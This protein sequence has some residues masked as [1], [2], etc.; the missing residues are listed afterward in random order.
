VR[1]LI[2]TLFFVL[3][4][5]PLAIAQPVFDAASSIA[6]DAVIQL[7]VAHTATGANR[8]AVIGVSHRV[9]TGQSITGISYGAQTPTSVIA[10]TSSSFIEGVL[11]RLI[12]PNTGSQ[13]LTV[14][15]GDI[16]DSAV[17]GVSTFT[18]VNQSTPLGTASSSTG[19]STASS[20]S[21]T[22]ASGELVTDLI[23]FCGPTNVVVGSGQ[24]SRWT[25]LTG[26]GNIYGGSSTEVGAGSVT[27]SW[28][29]D[30]EECWVEL[31]VSIKSFI[32]ATIRRV[33]P[34]VMQ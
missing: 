34:M 27:M 3:A 26:N 12:A 23:A 1:R 11:Y 15:F 29:N 19:L 17:I 32:A 33:G 21:V 20:T 9:D 6:G 16:F 2:V 25:Q 7:Q 5:L 30:D 24:T 4:W 22:S 10:A 8:L 28:S 18:N 31:G 13:T 14:N